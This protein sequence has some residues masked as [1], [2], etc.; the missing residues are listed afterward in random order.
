MAT[1]LESA[2]YKILCLAI[3]EAERLA[4]T[5]D[6]GAGYECLLTGMYRAV[7][8]AASG[9]TWGDPLAQSYRT[10][11]DQYRSLH[12]RGLPRSARVPA[13]RPVGA[14]SPEVWRQMWRRVSR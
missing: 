2:E 1:L 4:A 5:G 12:Q 6:V 9:E 14:D 3:S 10:A 8:H 13:V 11:L 7:E